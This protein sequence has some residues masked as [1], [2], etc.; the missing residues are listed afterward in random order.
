MSL[1]GYTLAMLQ[2]DLVTLLG[3]LKQTSWSL[4]QLTDAV[5]LAIKRLC[6]IKRYTYLEASVTITNS[7]EAYGIASLTGGGADCSDYLEIR[8]CLFSPLSQPSVELLQSN[9][10]TESER[11]PNWRSLLGIPER[12]LQRDGTTIL[13]TPYGGGY[14][15]LISSLIV[16]YV[17]SPTLLVNQ[18][19]LPD[20]RIPLAMHQYLK[21]AGASWLLSLDQTDTTAL[22][23]A[24]TYMD[25]FVGLIGA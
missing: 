8:R 13:V 9:I 22:Q 20:P 24:K 12:W 15:P 19:D 11:N 4:A 3:D 17:Q 21:Y 25:T 23:T 14:Q 18:T 1:T 10:E 5:N 7:A 6:T 2:A 16:C